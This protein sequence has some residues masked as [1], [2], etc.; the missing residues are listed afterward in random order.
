MYSSSNNGQFDF[1][2]N[3]QQNFDS[4]IFS[5]IYVLFLSEKKCVGD[6]AT[7]PFQAIKQSM[8]SAVKISF[9]VVNIHNRTLN[10]FYKTWYYTWSRR[11][12]L[13]TYSPLLSTFKAMKAFTIYI[14]FLI[15]S[16]ALL[17]RILLVQL[18]CIILNMRTFSW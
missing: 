10:A 5:R 18:V 7:W 15:S 2:I 12:A 9:T 3:C 17:T 13:C 8:Q 4:D 1:L 14:L 16:R 11:V 6:L